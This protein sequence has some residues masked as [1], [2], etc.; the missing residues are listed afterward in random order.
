MTSVRLLILFGG[1]AKRLKEKQV[2]T[3]GHAPIRDV[4]Q[5]LTCSSPSSNWRFS[6]KRTRAKALRYIICMSNGCCFPQC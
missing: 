2:Q 3:K 6:E 1:T 5:S 4:S